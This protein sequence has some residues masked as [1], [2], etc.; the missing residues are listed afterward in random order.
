MS[1][2]R[3]FTGRESSAGLV[4]SRE[5][6]AAPIAHGRDNPL[7]LLRDAITQ[8]KSSTGVLPDREQAMTL[9]AE[10]REALERA[11]AVAHALSRCDA[12][13]AADSFDLALVAL[14][15]GLHLYP[16]DSILVARR[17][18]VEERQKAF[19]SAAAV[20]G[21]IQEARWL[22]DHDRTDLA[23]GLLKQK[24]EE[25]PNQVE[26]KARLAEL[27]ALLPKWE[28]KRQV[29][30][31]LAR[32][33]TLEQLRQ[34]HAA[35]TVIGEALEAYPSSAELRAAA[36]RIAE[37]LAEDERQKKL[38]R[39]I[40]LIRQ[41]MAAGSWRQ[42]LLLTETTQREFA[43]ANELEPLGREILV[44][45]RRSEREEALIEVRK[46]LDDGELEIAE[47]AF[48]RARSAL[49]ADPAL[50]ALGRELEA[51]QRY[52][53]Q[54]RQAQVLFGRRQFED[55]ERILMQPLDRDRPESQAFL[56][57][58][59]AARAASEEANLLEDGREKARLLAG[60][61]DFAQ[62][63]D[64]LR[65]LLSL[66]PGNPI[67]ERDLETAHAG[68]EQQVGSIGEP[69]AILGVISEVS[70]A[71]EAMSSAPE[72][73]CLQATLPANR[74]PRPH[75]EPPPALPQ[76]RAATPPARGR[77]RFAALAGATA[78]LLA[79]AAGIGWKQSQ[80]RAP[81]PKPAAKPPSV[82]IESL[83]PAVNQ[84][85]PPPI[86]EPSDPKTPPFPPASEHQSAAAAG[87]SR[88]QPTTPAKA[89]NT[90]QPR[91]FVP[92][93]AGPSEAPVPTGALPVAPGTSPAIYITTIPAMP[94]LLSAQPNVAAPPPPIA[95]AP[96]PAAPKPVAAVGGN[97]GE[98]QLITR[99][100]PTYSA[101]AQEQR[102]TGEVRL[103][104]SIDE[105][106]DVK[107]VKIL[108]GN[109]LL[110]AAA[111]NAVM[112]WKYRP[113]TLN[114]QPVSTSAEIRFDFVGRDR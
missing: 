9:L 32:A 77:F 111:R 91:A 56:E 19:H 109:P 65:N 112:Q 7:Q 106:G 98:A 11:N 62:A 63:A 57:A 80:S 61:K 37:H 34:R 26:L 96:P 72:V 100:L 86:A 75:F 13:V 20:R 78:S 40:E 51:E 22:L 35:L 76:S 104:A 30:D 17:Q 81:A 10:A 39:R 105:H 68:L 90:P 46:C 102:F 49:G 14:D 99:V 8:L 73:M 110:A 58:V 5:T 41:Q 52:F 108:G 42:A 95:A 70:S 82:F 47:R 12:H 21:A 45:L 79:L 16:G 36:E 24:A 48:Q 31:A 4:V 54:L 15:E 2:A 103:T 83:A 38:A 69:E 50:E 66:F 101:R 59:R 97:V 23:A 67:L 44:G 74:E 89:S 18:E 94:A 85:Y 84:T 60:Q 87:Q 71:P 92:P 64:L 6:P 1:A 27:Q 93:S 114:G 88:R 25:F 107:N 29:R 53:G 43:G 113:A 33:L 3:Q 55:A 28:E